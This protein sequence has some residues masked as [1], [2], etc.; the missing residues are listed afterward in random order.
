MS[1]QHY[2]LAIILGLELVSLWVMVTFWLVKPVI[3]DEKGG[4]VNIAPTATAVFSWP[5]IWLTPWWGSRATPTPTPVPANTLAAQFERAG[6][7][8]A[9]VDWAFVTDYLPDSY[10]Y[11]WYSRPESAAQT[12]GEPV[13]LVALRS[14]DIVYFAVLESCE[15]QAMRFFERPVYA[16][17]HYPGSL[18][19]MAGYWP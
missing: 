3:G 16:R 1:K 17:Q 19:E 10:V 15:G 5:Q 12:Q 9:C 4:A 6:T 2:A 11:R 18:V 7:P 13:E 14:G 8:F